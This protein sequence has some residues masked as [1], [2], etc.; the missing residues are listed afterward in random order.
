MDFITALLT[1]RPNAQWSAPTGATMATEVIWHDDSDPVTQSEL[2][3]KMAEPASEITPA[4]KL[5]RAGLTVD[6]LK[7]LLGLSTPS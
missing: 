7:E 3:A 6:E 2:E 4:E 1:L 5:A